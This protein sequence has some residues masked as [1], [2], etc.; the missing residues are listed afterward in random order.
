MVATQMVDSLV[1]LLTSS[2]KPE[3]VLDF[4]LPLGLQER[5]SLLLELNRE[6]IISEEEKEELD[7]FI[8]I[9]HIFRMAKARARMQMAEA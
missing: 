5:A 3:D 2:P 7:Q 4:K 1:T 8:F 9:E 6:G